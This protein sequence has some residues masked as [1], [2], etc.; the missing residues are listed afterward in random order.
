MEKGDVEL[1]II[2]KTVLLTYTLD[3]QT[4]WTF[5]AVNCSSA[6]PLEIAVNEKISEVRNFQYHSH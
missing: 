1:E 3:T 4:E 5:K 6:Y 2:S